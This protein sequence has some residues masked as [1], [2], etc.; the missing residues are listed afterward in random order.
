M[1]L[2]NPSA[3]S[4]APIA[5]KRTGDVIQILLA[6]CLGVVLL[7]GVGFAH[8]PVLHNAA[9]DTRHANGFPCH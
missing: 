8:V 4:P 1:S 6:A 9:H 2:Q 7:A 3:V 5:G